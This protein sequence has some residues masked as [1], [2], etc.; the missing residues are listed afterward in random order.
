MGYPLK[1][2]FGC[3][4]WIWLSKVNGPA[5]PKERWIKGFVC[6]FSPQK[7]LCTIGCHRNNYIIEDLGHS[8]GTP[9][10]I[11]WV[12]FLNKGLIRHLIILGN[13]HFKALTWIW[14]SKVNGPAFPKE[15]WIKGFV[16][17]F[18]PQK[19]LCTIGCHRNNYIIEDLG[20][21][22]GTPLK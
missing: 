5:F 10:K 19:F 8:W 6:F 12:L 16:C 7:F 4:T 21:S 14:L 2:M 18:S 3:L 22:W 13:L 11:V 17:F 1:K 20:H 9:W 15:R